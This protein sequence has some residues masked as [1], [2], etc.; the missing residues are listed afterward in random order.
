MAPINRCVKDLYSTV[1]KHNAIS[2]SHKGWFRLWKIQ[3]SRSQTEQLSN[4]EYHH[5]LGHAF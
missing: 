2:D 4:I 5:R 3:V 1:N